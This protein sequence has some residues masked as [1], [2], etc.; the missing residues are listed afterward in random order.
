[1][2][3]RSTNI[4]FQLLAIFA[5]QMLV[6]FTSGLS[7]S[8]NDQNYD[9]PPFAVIQYQGEDQVIHE[10]IDLPSGIF[11]EEVLEEEEIHPAPS[12][13]LATFVSVQK[14]PTLYLLNRYQLVLP[15]HSIPPEVT[16]IK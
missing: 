1:M 8:A 4:S 3:D 5:W 9:L 15:T 2:K 11:V 16:V 12:Y 10:K 14:H 6:L 13:L 7:V